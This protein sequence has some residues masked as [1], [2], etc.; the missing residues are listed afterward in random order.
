VDRFSAEVEK[1]VRE[2]QAVFGEFPIF[3]AGVYTFIADYLPNAQGDGMEHRNSTILTSPGTIR[4]REDRQRELEGVAHEFFH[5]WNVERIRPR[6]LEPFDFERA[7]MSAELWLA[8]GFTSYYQIVLMARSGL[9][10]VSDTSRDLAQLVNTVTASPA[11]R[12]RSAADMSRLA[13]FVDAARWVDRTNWENTFIS[14]YTWGAAIGLGLD[15]TLRERSKGRVTLDDFMRAMWREYGRPAAPAPGVV[16]IPYTMADARA[17]LAEVAGDRAFADEF[18]DRY[19][20]GREIVDY[21]TLLGRA[22]FATVLRRPGMAT[23]GPVPLSYDGDGA[24]LSG[25]ALI[26]TPLYEAGLDIDDV[27]VALDGDPVTS[28]DRLEAYLRRHAP[29]HRSTVTYRR[30]GIVATST[31]PLAADASIDIRALERAGADQR[32]FRE[33]WLGSRASAEALVGQRP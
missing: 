28:A 16:A 24:R 1:I 6:S 21:K 32:A 8:E 7:N 33:S 17:R 3:D 20:E 2:T 31:V 13:P 4:T 30:R 23:L 27:I 19:I 12:F 22:G 14:Y 10:S 26:G 15:L 18:F 11:R 9:A 29:G 25:P 5:A